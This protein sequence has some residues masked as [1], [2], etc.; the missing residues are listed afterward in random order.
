MALSCY[1]KAVEFLKDA[2]EGF[3]ARKY[4]KN[5]MYDNSPA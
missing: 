4:F 1:K 5:K 3:R 2:D